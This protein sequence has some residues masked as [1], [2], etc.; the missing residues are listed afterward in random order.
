MNGGL[1]LTQ[2][3]FLQIDQVLL[4]VRQAGRPNEYRI[5][6]F[7]LHEAVVRDPTESDLSHSEVVSL[8]D[9]ADAIESF[10][11]GLLPVAIK[12]CAYQ[13]RTSGA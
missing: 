3:P 2:G 13:L 5:T 1:A 10:E 6:V 9:G 4:D 12:C 11:I 7:A 8:R